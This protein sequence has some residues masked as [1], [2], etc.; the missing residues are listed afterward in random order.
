MIG[1]GSES[2]VYK[3]RIK[4]NKREIALKMISLKKSKA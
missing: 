1:F 4:K 2:E 3:A